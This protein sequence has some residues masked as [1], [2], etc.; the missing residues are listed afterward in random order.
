MQQLFTSQQG[1]TRQTGGGKFKQKGKAA[2][3]VIKG[4]HDHNHLEEA[5]LLPSSPQSSMALDLNIPPSDDEEDDLF[6]G[7]H[8]QDHPPAGAHPM[9]AS[10]VDINMVAYQSGYRIF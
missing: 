1:F 6:G 4:H 10:S 5:Q 2:A 9:A 3:P 8:G 7:T